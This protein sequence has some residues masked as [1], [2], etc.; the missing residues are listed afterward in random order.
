[1]NGKKIAVIAGVSTVTI[2]IVIAIV[3][4]ANKEPEK[5]RSVQKR[6]RFS[7]KNKKKTF[8][9]EE[10]PSNI[11]EDPVSQLDLEEDP[12]TF[13]DNPILERRPEMSVD[14]F[15]QKR[16]LNIQ[17]NRD[18][19]IGPNPHTIAFHPTPSNFLRKRD[20]ITSVDV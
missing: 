4:L 8:K 12:V 18:T 17:Y 2:A 16:Q 15:T 9:T 19:A 14:R 10:S 1:M 6:V 3:L 7:P 20:S 5:P 13:I 11:E